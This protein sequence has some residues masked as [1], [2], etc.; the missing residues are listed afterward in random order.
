[1]KVEGRGFVSTTTRCGYDDDLM[2]KIGESIIIKP[3]FCFLSRIS[4]EKDDPSIHPAQQKKKKKS[5]PLRCGFGMISGALGPS[6]DVRAVV[7]LLRY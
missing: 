1:M 6:G 2:M 3:S 4:R 5:V 7:A